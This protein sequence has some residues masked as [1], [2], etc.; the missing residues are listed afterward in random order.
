MTEDK[1]C[2]IKYSSSTEDLD[3]NGSTQLLSVT[4]LKDDEPHYS[5]QVEK[6]NDKFW[7]ETPFRESNNCY[8]YACN[9]KIPAS[10][11]WPHPGYHPG[12]NGLDCQPP[13]DD[14]Q[15]LEGINNDKIIKI[16]NDMIPPDE[17]YPVWRVGL[18]SG[19]AGKNGEEWSYHFYREVLYGN[20]TCW[21]HKNGSGKA[22]ILDFII[23]PEDPEDLEDLKNH[24]KKLGYTK[25]HGL[26]LVPP[27]CIY[28]PRY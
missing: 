28:G 21:S 9:I 25:W 26:F 5:Y 14:V 27:I 3:E 22:E 8:A 23:N 11:K 7:N 20:K 12:Y 18:A 19:Y 2:Y 4:V 13:T 15:L 16:K 6:F 1:T 17:D 24:A 10:R